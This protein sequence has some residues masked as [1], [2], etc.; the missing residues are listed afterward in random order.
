MAILGS[1]NRLSLLVTDGPARLLIATGD[2]PI[3][4]ENALTRVRPIFARRIDVLLVA[5]DGA[6]LLVPL[7]A[8]GDRHVRTAVALAPLP[9]SA[10]AEGFGAIDVFSAPRRIR[11]GPAVQV[12]METAFP[13]GADPATDFPVWRATIEHGQTRVV[14]LSDGEAASL[15]PPSDPASVL[16]VS[17]DDPISASNLAPAVAMVANAEVIDGRELRAAAAEGR[18]PPQWGFLVHRNE[19]L[20]LHFIPGGVEIASDSAQNLSTTND[21]GDRVT[22]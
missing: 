5:G 10:E 15:F 3:A 11:L 22:E 9:V 1:G 2:D 14:M 7:A 16:I 17:G 20:R 12:T 8:R 21:T 6:S 4:Y 19:A 18:R 13:F